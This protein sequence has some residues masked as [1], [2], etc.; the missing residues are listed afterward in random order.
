MRAYAVEIVSD[1]AGWELHLDTD[2]GRVIF[3]VHLCAEDLLT[4][5]GK[6]GRWLAEGRAAAA[7]YVPPPTEEDL[8]AYPPGDPKRITLEREM[9]R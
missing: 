6:I 9:R 7:S 4:E 1:E 2:E 5:A 3:N 8:D